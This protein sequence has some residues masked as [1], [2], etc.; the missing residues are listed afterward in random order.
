MEKE[1][2]MVHFIKYNNAIPIAL[3]F[4]FLSTTATF[5][6][7]PAAR[8]AV[9]ATETSVRSVDNSY[10]IGANLARYDFSMR[11]TS[12]T[13]DADWYY[14]LYQMDTIDVVDGVW[15]D[16][17]A[18]RELRISKALLRDGDLRAYAESELA[19][20][21]YAER[22]RLKKT[23]E[24]EKRLGISQKMVATVYTGLVGK[25]IEPDTSTAPFYQPPPEKQAKNDPLAV[26][27][28]KPLVTWDA[29]DVP[30]PLPEPEEEPEP[31]EPPP[32]PPSEPPA[33]TT[34]PEEP[35]EPPAEEP[36][37]EPEPEPEPEPIPEPEP[38]PAPEPPP[39]EPAEPAQ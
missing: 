27:N 2:G 24:Y 13:E 19:Q 29:N 35:A 12:I 10:I 18:E 8:E 28:P 23:Q 9:Y 30:E 20:V 37:P 3:G 22:E 36:V 38:E 6:A 14:L 17:V 34:P 33:T 26:K 5:A 21:E 31:Q 1:N 7:V 15:K 11:V 4:L 32:I 25:L 39:S 16:T